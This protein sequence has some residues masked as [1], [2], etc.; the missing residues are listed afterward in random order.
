MEILAA[1]FYEGFV[2]KKLTLY[3]QFYCSW[4]CLERKRWNMFFNIKKVVLFV[5]YVRSVLLD[6]GFIKILTFQSNFP[7]TI[8][9]V[10]AILKCSIKRYSSLLMDAMYTD[11]QNVK[12]IL[13]AFIK[14]AS[15]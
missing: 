13:K 7:S 11:N 1:E 10:K 2:V 3:T 5:N 9:C 8:Y 12:E 6:L 4:N 14:L 15:I